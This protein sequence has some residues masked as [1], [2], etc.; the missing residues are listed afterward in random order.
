[1]SF[2]TNQSEYESLVRALGLENEE[3]W[4]QQ[5]FSLQTTLGLL[6]GVK[7]WSSILINSAALFYTRE[8]I[9]KDKEY[10]ANSGIA[11]SKELPIIE[12]VLDAGITPEEIAEITVR[13]QWETAFSI[14]YGLDD[15]ETEH[16]HYDDP[17]WGVY[18]T[19]EEERV[20]GT[21]W[22]SQTDIL[23][24]TAPRGIDI[25]EYLRR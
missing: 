19:D 4:L 10:A 23:V 8:A 5:E 3:A 18:S 11:P 13:P 17:G 21:R 12:K 16:H 22:G 1:M 25:E 24:M 2:P 7:V 6:F 9:A 14:C 20:V 15:W